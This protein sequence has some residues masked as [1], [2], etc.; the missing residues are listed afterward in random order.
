MEEGNC[1]I[2]INAKFHALRHTHASALIANGI[3]VVTIRRRLGHCS[4]AFTLRVY[5]HKCTPTDTTA[6]T[7][8]G[9]LLGLSL[10]A[11]PVPIPGFW[12]QKWRI[13]GT[14]C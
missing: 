3:D 8:I 10:G 9:K 4:A 7:A 13:C 14:S 6:A 12:G 1:P 2:G 11:H 5:A